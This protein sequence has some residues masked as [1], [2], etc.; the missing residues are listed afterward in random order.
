MANSQT[1]GDYKEYATVN[2]T[3]PAEGYWTNQ[4][5]LRR[6]KIAYA[7]FSIRGTGVATVT[8]QFKCE[9]DS[10]WTDFNNDGTTF[11][12]GDRKV[13]EGNAGNVLWRAGV[14]QAD[15]TSGEV[16]FGFDW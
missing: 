15:Y 7:F 11:V 9:G 13:L 1:S 3:P 6:K 8:L 4:L 16:R 12:T 14:K 5:G 10:D 2:T